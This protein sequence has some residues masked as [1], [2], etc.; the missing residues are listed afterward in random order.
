MKATAMKRSSFAD[1]GLIN[2]RNRGTE[3]AFSSPRQRSMPISANSAMGEQFEPSWRFGRAQL[4][5]LHI[6]A[7]RLVGIRGHAHH[8]DL[9]EDQRIIGCPH[10]ERGSCVP[11]LGGALEDDTSC[12]HV[13]N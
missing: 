12:R 2:H 3:T 10:G 9:V 5:G 11:G 7:A 4:L 6:P 1:S 13:A 8:A